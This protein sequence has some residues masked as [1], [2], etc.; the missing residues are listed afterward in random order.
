M[1]KVY[2]G[3]IPTN[4]SP[5]EVKALFEKY[6]TVSDCDIIK[7]YAFVVGPNQWNDTATLS[8][9]LASK[10]WSTYNKMLL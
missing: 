7:N 8:F 1:S 4:S 5:D 6:G 2:V 10:F 9:K 3:N